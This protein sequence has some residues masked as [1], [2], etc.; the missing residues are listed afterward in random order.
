MLNKDFS[1]GITPLTEECIGDIKE[2]EIESGLSSWTIEDYIKEI[3]RPD[4]I[5]FAAKN[6]GVIKG[7]LISRLIMSVITESSTNINAE[8]SVKE[9]EVEIYNLAVKKEARKQGIGQALLNALLSRSREYKILNVWLEVRE[10][11]IPAI[12]FYTKNGF[13]KTHLR[14]NFYRFPVENGLLMKLEL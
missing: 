13:I 5:A 12:S 3:S 4:S 7:F 14:K 10:S 11:N 2:I 8:D 9:N 1:T 6:N